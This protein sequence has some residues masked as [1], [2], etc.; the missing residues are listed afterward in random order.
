VYYGSLKRW[1]SEEVQYKLPAWLQLLGL[2]V[3]VVL[4]MSLV[5]S[6]VLKHQ[7]NARTRQLTQINQEMEQRIIERAAELAAAMERAQAADR[8]KSAFL[9]TMSH[10][11]HTPMN[12]I[13]GFTQLLLRESEVQ[14]KHRTSLET[15]RRSGEYLLKLLNDVLEMSK[16]EAGRTTLNAG[17]CYLKARNEQ[18][19]EELKQ[20]QG[21]LQA[22]IENIP[23]M[24]FVKNSSN[25]R[26]LRFNSHHAEDCR[27][28][29]GPETPRCQPGRENPPV[30]RIR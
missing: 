13:P 20:S 22:I 3:G 15:V 24:I 12:A 16:I 18:L 9:A 2:V 26:F 23:D 28:R 17:V 30:H 29:V 14:P 19:F 10:E 8:I 11:I 5:A 4:L 1:T 6:I 21:F 27:I 25:L 7:V